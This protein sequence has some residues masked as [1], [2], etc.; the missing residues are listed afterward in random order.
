MPVNGRKTMPLM[1]LKIVVLAQIPSASASIA[2]TVKPGALT[3]IRRAYRRSWRI[4]MLSSSWL[5]LYAAKKTQKAQYILNFWCFFM[6]KNSG[7]EFHRSFGRIVYEAANLCLPVFHAIVHHY[8]KFQCHWSERCSRSAGAFADFSVGRSDRHPAV[9]N[10]LDG[11][12]RPNGN[13]R[14]QLAGQFI[15]CLHVGAPSIFDQ[16]CDAGYSKRPR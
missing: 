9:H 3:I 14:L 6:A 11:G 5:W 16:R 1:R 12:Q 15:V 2:R 4:D 7:L 8:R 13:R 10:L